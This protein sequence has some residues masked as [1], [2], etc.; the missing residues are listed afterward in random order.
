MIWNDIKEK[1][2]LAYITGIFDGKKSDKVLAC[3]RNRKYHIVEMYEGFMDNSE[4]CDFYDCEDYE[5]TNITHWTVI[6]SPF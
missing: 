4:F 3:D 2:P 6:D 5:I 1:K